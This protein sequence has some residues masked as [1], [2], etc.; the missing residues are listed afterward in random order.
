M[1]DTIGS[2]RSSHIIATNLKPTA[3]VMIEA[4]DTV[5]ARLS[6]DNTRAACLDRPS[7]WIFGIVL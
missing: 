1:A 4:S 5:Q 3:R 6:K 7:I 2:Y